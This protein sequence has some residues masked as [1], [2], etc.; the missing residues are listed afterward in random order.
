MM[1]TIRR[2]TVALA[3]LF[4]LSVGLAACDDAGQQQQGEAPAGEQQSQ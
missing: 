2:L 1:S 3:A 4:A